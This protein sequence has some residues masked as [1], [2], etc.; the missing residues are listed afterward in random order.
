MLLV[1]ADVAL[2]GAG[3]PFLTLFRMALVST[4]ADPDD[5]ADS[6]REDAADDDD[7]DDDDAELAALLDLVS[8]MVW[9]FW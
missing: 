7:G 9:L 6:D 3:K 2:D 5:K 1:V 4:T 8:G